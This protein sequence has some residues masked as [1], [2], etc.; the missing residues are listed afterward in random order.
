MR[1]VPRGQAL[2]TTREVVTKSHLTKTMDL[3]D[4]FDL[5]N[6]LQSLAT[7]V[8]ADGEAPR[9]HGQATSLQA[10][11]GDTPITTTGLIKLSLARQ[12]KTV[13]TGDGGHPEIRERASLA[14]EGAFWAAERA[15]LILSIQR[16]APEPQQYLMATE[17]TMIRIIREATKE[18]ARTPITPS[19]K[20]ASACYTLAAH[21][22]TRRQVHVHPAVS[23]LG[24]IVAETWSAWRSLQRPYDRLRASTTRGVHATEVVS[25]GEYRLF[26]HPGG[27]CLY[28]GGHAWYGTLPVFLAALEALENIAKATL[29]MTVLRSSEVEPAVNPSLVLRIAG[30]QWDV[31][32]AYGGPGHAVAKGIEA[33]AKALANTRAGADPPRRASGKDRMIEKYRAKERELHPGG[34]TPMSDALETLCEPLQTPAGCC[35]ASGLLRFCGYPF[36]NPA[37][38]SNS[39]RLQSARPSRARIEAIMDCV[40]ILK[41]LVLK[42]YLEKHGSW[43]EIDWG[44]SPRR[45]ALRRKH[46]ASSLNLPDRSYPLSDWHGVSIVN[47]TKFM[48]H[49]D[50]LD[51]IADKASNEGLRLKGEAYAGRLSSTTV[52]RLIHRILESE[53]IVTKDEVERFA[54]DEMDPDVFAAGLAPKGGEFKAEARAYTIIHY[55]VR[56]VLSIVQE[57]VKECIFP[58]LPYTSMAMGSAELSRTLHAMS[59]SSNG[60]TWL[61]ETDMSRWN[62]QFKRF[63]SELAGAELDKMC[64]VVGLF[65]QSHRF[66]QRSEFSITTH[67]ARIDQLENPELRE[68]KQ[69]GPQMFWGDEGGKEGIEQ[70]FWTVLTVTMFYYAL[71]DEPYSFRLLGQGDNQTLAIALGTLTPDQVGDETTRLSAKIDQR[72]DELNHIAK[73]EEFLDGVSGLPLE[74]G[75][76]SQGI[77]TYSKVF[78]QA[79][80]QL[81]METKFGMKVGATED[82]FAPSLETSLGS[83]FS[84]GVGVARNARRPLD[85]WYLSCLVAE[86][87]LKEVAIDGGPYPE[88]TRDRASALVRD[89]GAMI[90]SLMLPSCVGGFPVVP[91]PAFLY[92]GDPDPLSQAISMIRASSASSALFR[93]VERY[94]ARDS[95]YVPSPQPTR[96]LEDPF[97]IPLR[98]AQSPASIVKESATHILSAARNREIADLA[99]ATQQTSAAF[100]QSLLSM[101][102]LHPL[103]LKDML[104]I[105]IIGRC[106]RILG[107][108]QAT[109]SIGKVIREM[110]NAERIPELSARRLLL[111]TLRLQAMSTAS[112]EVGPLLPRGLSHEVADAIRCRWGLGSGVIQGVSTVQPLDWV[113][114]STP[115]PGVVVVIDADADFSRAGPRLPYFSTRTKE[116]RAEREYEVDRVP[117]STDLAKLVLSYTAGAVG[118]VARMI[119]EAIASSRTDLSLEDLAVVFP[120]T[121]GGTPAHRYD[122]LQGGGRIGPIGNPATRAFMEVDTDNIPGLSASAID[123]PIPV[124]AFMSMGLALSAA[125]LSGPR[126]G[127]RLLRIHLTTSALAPIV[128]TGREATQF[129]PVLPPMRDNPLA[130]VV[131]LDAVSIA[132]RLGG[133]REQL[134]DHLESRA[135]ALA[136]LLTLALTTSGAGRL[137][138]DIAPDTASLAGIDQGVA[139]TLGGWYT[140]QSVV[141]AVSVAATWYITWYRGGDIDRYSLGL[142]VDNLSASASN[143]VLPLLHH[144]SVDK[145]QLTEEGVWVPAHGTAGRRAIDDCFRRSVRSSAMMRLRDVGGLLDLCVGLTLPE[146]VQRP[147]PFYA[148]RVR[149]GLAVWTLASHASGVAIGPL[150]REAAE[151]AKSVA[152]GGP[153]LEITD[154]GL[155]LALQR[156]LATLEDLALTVDADVLEA[157]GAMSGRLRTIDGDATT[158]LRRI[159]VPPSVVDRRPV[160]IREELAP[161][162]G[163]RCSFRVPPGDRFSLSQMRGPLGDAEGRSATEVLQERACRTHGVRST[164]G[165]VWADP[166]TDSRGPVLVVGTGA[167]GIQKVLASRGIES[168]GLDLA[169]TLPVGSRASLPPPGEASLY[170]DLATLSPLMLSTSGNWLDED[171][172]REAMASRPWGTVVIDIETGASRAGSEL[173]DPLFEARFRGRILVRWFLTRDETTS[174]LSILAA[175]YGV[176]RV[177]VMSGGVRPPSNISRPVIFVID[178]RGQ[179]GLKLFGG[180]ANITAWPNRRLARDLSTP[181]E[182]FRRASL[183]LTGGLVQAANIA[184]LVGELERELD[185]AGRSRGATHHGTL[186]SIMRVY[187]S[188]LPLGR[189]IEDWSAGD[190]LRVPPTLD[191]AVADLTFRVESEGA[192]GWTTHTVTLAPND[193]AVVYNIQK[194]IPRLLAAT[195]AQLQ[196]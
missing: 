133:T 139:T 86:N 153:L 97:A 174:C 13:A 20:A 94:L 51:L 187:A 3:D 145:V 91:W 101:R 173:L 172:S 137:A 107:K 38:S 112:G 96:L 8:D 9:R 10:R 125:R 141:R 176:R 48:Y 169:S 72:C 126:P 168:V 117:G 144:R 53:S 124:Q 155:G 159:R 99:R 37:T 19:H 104:D 64:G 116:R 11:L 128:D 146:V 182:Q 127:E 188:I 93:G 58:Y 111:T 47:I 50:Y 59:A 56:M 32:D 177:R 166:L 44:T 181:D 103:L 106:N 7:A 189:V 147:P 76:H 18:G 63:W 49:S 67:D 89:E 73:P 81:P 151:L 22:L 170:P 66:F 183:V 138:A 113:V 43:P 83:I 54:L 175:T 135:L 4:D 71:W 129:P 90:L 33:Y 171:V 109:A 156:L 178:A 34:L 140:Y 92:S 194:I 62:L 196:V 25:L 60:I 161:G 119:Y 98:Q 186:K 163:E 190:E 82:E 78:Y 27:I 192:P 1:G 150:K 68:A 136:G 102:P 123:W 115:G 6:Y 5:Q 154:A 160:T 45:T 143:S 79:G 195:W 110:G 118:P 16:G 114:S 12:G 185:A 180:R 69:S 61:L 70:R 30:W 95:S 40:S 88:F 65:G 35:E 108:F 52:R 184:D 157:V 46:S 84:A 77:L 121:V 130:H 21:A 105:S 179:G 57:N 193:P 162:G 15:E 17:A 191:E 87:Y 55:K 24:G 149:I 36:V 148:L 75:G 131:S 26:L 142:L 23:D 28:K 41:H 134:E 29:S 100:C 132:T 85:C 167:G 152:R 164:I 2:W 14:R 39:S 31:V 42:N 74:G 120:G 80:R 122:S 165:Q 158:I